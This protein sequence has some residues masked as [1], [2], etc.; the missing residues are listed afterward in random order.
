LSG[1]KICRD[2]FALP[3]L[4]AGC[5]EGPV[6]FGQAVAVEIDA[7]VFGYRRHRAGR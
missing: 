1:F 3:P 4:D 6:V 5:G 2:L 7:T